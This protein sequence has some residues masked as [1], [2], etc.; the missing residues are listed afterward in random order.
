MTFPVEGRTE[1]QIFDAVDDVTKD[2]NDKSGDTKDEKEDTETPED[3]EETPE[4]NEEKDD[5]DSDEPPQPKDEENEDEEGT[6]N[7]EETDEVYARIKKVSPELFKKVPELKQIIFR[8]QEY[9]N[10]FPTVKEAKEA[11]DTLQTFQEFN[12]DI[13]NGNSAKLIG[14]LETVGK[15][16]LNSFLANFL[17]TVQK[18]SKDLYLQVVYPEIKKAL[19]AA[20]KSGDERL[21]VSAKNL[22]WFI[23]GDHD[24]DGKVGL[25][26][27]EKDGR[28]SELEERERKFEEKQ[29]TSFAKDVAVTGKS[30]VERVISRAFEESGLSSLMQKKLVE[31]IFTRVDEIISKDVRFQ[32]NNNN[33][34]KQAKNNG[35][36]SNWKDSIINA[37][38]SRAKLLIPKVRQQVLA[39]AKLDAKIKSES[40]EG[41]EKKRIPTT[42]TSQRNFTGGK[43]DKSKVDWDK[44]S[45]RDI[46]DGKVT[47][48]S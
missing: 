8:E 10:V 45:E 43:I 36:T 23:F 12:E 42:S 38:L 28:E 27:K 41:R 31:E 15:D 16:A 26:P 22:H 18:H 30:R 4:D 40:E 35:F 48:K 20:I 3:A 44:T 21:E 32:G 25:E 7:L 5:E 9:T 37:Y 14:A 46:W 47:Y 24:I 19:K 34:W 39:E 6:E 2:K 17:P 1:R 11:L 33:L 13:G 29:F